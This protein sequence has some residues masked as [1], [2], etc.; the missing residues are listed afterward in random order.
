MNKKSHV[1][2]NLVL[3]LYQVQTIAP[4]PHSYFKS[5]VSKEDLSA[6]EV[7]HKSS[8]RTWYTFTAQSLDGLLN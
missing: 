6:C 7:K 2:S 1:T 5:Q 4:Q 8:K 3:K